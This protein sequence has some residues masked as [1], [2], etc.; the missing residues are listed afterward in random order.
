MS[1]GV[2]M[3]GDYAIALGACTVDYN[4]K[5]GGNPVHVEGKWVCIQNARPMNHGKV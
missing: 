3:S 4:S 1:V 5:A 2:R